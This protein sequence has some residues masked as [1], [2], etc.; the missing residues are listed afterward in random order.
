[1]QTASKQRKE[2]PVSGR[3]IAAFYSVDPHTVRRWRYDGCPCEVIN[4]KLIRYYPSQV[5][6][7]LRSRPVKN[8]LSAAAINAR[9]EQMV[10][11]RLK[12]KEMPAFSPSR[13]I[14]RRKT[15][16]VIS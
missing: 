2:T 10:A 12:E 6:A 11:E 13:G 5:D 15:E 1:M 3:E 9:V 14:K 16:V 7:W 8:P 4:A